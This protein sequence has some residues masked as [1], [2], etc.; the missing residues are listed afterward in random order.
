MTLR[1][2]RAISNKV[3]LRQRLSE[4]S[5]RCYYIAS[6]ALCSNV[7]PVILLEVQGHEAGIE[8]N[9]APWSSQFLVMMR[10]NFQERAIRPRQQSV[11]EIVQS[12]VPHH[13]EV[14]FRE[15]LGGRV[16]RDSEKENI[17]LPAFF[18][19]GP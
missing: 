15:V 10:Q 19:E 11:S 12:N 14:V 2:S 6:H 17:F 4:E 8:F 5:L 13:T 16:L 7:A 18:H 9:R 1:K 3:K